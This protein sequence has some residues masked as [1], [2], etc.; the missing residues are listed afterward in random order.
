MQSFNNYPNIFTPLNAGPVRLK[1]RIQFSPIVSAHAHPET[2]DVTEGLVAWI[3][4]QARSGV[5]L[6][7]IGSTPVDFDRG[8][9]Y[10]GCLS[11]V[12]DSDV[13]QLIRLAEAAHRY[14]AKIS[15]EIMHAGR[16]AYPASLKGQKAFV[17]WL[18]PDLDPEKFEEISKRGIDEV[19]SHFCN[20]A[21][22]LQKAG[23]DMLMVHAAHGNLVSAFFSPLYNQRTDEYGGTMENRMRFTLTLLKRIRETIGPKMGIEMRISSNEYLEGSP[24][25]EDIIAFLQRAQEYID[26]V[27]LSGGLIFHPDLVK[28][29][30]PAYLEPRNV[31]VERSAIIRKHLNIPVAV[32]GNI[33]GIDA[34]EEILRDG[35][36]DVVAMARN[37]IADMDFVTKA[38]RG[39]AGEIRP[40]LHCVSCCLNPSKGAPLRCAVNPLAGQES[41][42]TKVE[43]AEQKKKVVVVGGGPAGMTAAQ[44]AVL[45]G[46]EVVLF[47]QNN[48][49][50]G[51]LYEASSM[52]CKDYFRQYIEWTIRETHRSGARIELG[53]KATAEIIGGEAPDAVILAIGA[54]HNVPPIKGI[55][56]SGFITVS[57]ADLRQKP[58]GKRVVVIGGGLSGS[59]CAIDLALEGH[60]VTILDKLPEDKL[61]TEV[62]GSVTES[63]RSLIRENNIETYFDVNISEI[64]PGCVVLCS[65]DKTEKEIPYDTLVLSVGL[66]PDQELLD[67]LANVI[68]DTFVIGDCRK[69][70]NILGAN[71]DGFFTALEI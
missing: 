19:I 60:H 16:I 24:S 13:P 12:K 41:L 54:E 62:M 64:R 25:L 56:N 29:M 65:N 26:L 66:T 63:L 48:F 30:M 49:L 27:H 7:T 70:R 67:I 52:K 1:N 32:V 9:D 14:D 15:C 2:G 61:L 71:G 5:S 39:Q 18:A 21:G 8:R 55:E 58:I 6:V 42:I 57:E 43:K 34:A 37:L 3:G 40:C 10:L 23:F 31:N 46:H 17:P 28:Y 50:G 68:P 53:K 51:K 47:E 38:R 22:R 59:E 20:V 33:P 45:R 44:T 11:A 35:K 69:V 36:A 4:A